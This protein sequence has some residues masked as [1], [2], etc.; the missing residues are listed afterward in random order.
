MEN[1]LTPTTKE[2]L[3]SL[4]RPVKMQDF[5]SGKA[6]EWGRLVNSSAV[7]DAAKQNAVIEPL[8]PG[9]RW[10]TAY[11]GQPKYEQNKVYFGIISNVL[12]WWFNIKNSTPANIQMDYIKKQNIM[13]HEY[14]A[15]TVAY[16]N[17]PAS[18]PLAVECLRR[19][20]YSSQIQIAIQ[21]FPDFWSDPAEFMPGD[22]VGSWPK[23]SRDAMLN[24]VLLS[25]KDDFKGRV[26]KALYL[27]GYK[28][29]IVQEI[30]RGK[31]PDIRKE[32]EEEE[33][34]KPKLPPVDKEKTKSMWLR[35]RGEK[36]P[37]ECGTTDSKNNLP[38]IDRLIRSTI[39]AILAADDPP[40]M[41]ELTGLDAALR[42]LD[43]WLAGR[44]D[45]HHRPYFERLREIGMR[46]YREAR[47][48]V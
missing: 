10:G 3:L 47:R 37:A 8:H 7:V 35:F 4:K 20:F 6:D 26:A 33:A 21:E 11:D 14:W 34:K 22:E 2:I 25:K 32:A 27:A 1:D 40:E 30:E 12:Y 43:W 18:K 23:E 42:N 44:I 48:E 39:K 46:V 31:L 16:V 38:G 41:G 45:E 9:Q 36:F 19:G 5:I 28:K 15:N 24:I 13:F 29:R 17:M